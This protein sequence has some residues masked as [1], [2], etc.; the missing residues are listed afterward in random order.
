MIE[1]HNIGNFGKLY[2]YKGPFIQAQEV[3]SP[4]K[5]PPRRKG[6]YQIYKE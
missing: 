3:N 2:N 4:Y 5:I 1:Y 6:R